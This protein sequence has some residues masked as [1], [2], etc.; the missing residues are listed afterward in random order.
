MLV[1]C[2]QHVRNLCFIQT[3]GRLHHNLAA[4]AGLLLH[5]RNSEN[6]IRVNLKR[7][8]NTGSTRD[9]WRN[10]GQLK[11]GQRTTV[12]HAFPLPLHHVHDQPGLAIPGGGK[13]LR[14]RNGDRTVAVDNTLYQPAVGLEAE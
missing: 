6:A 1:S 2:F 11:T 9:H 7:D 12:L 5:R 3:K 14:P 10:T 8:L 4:G 13:F